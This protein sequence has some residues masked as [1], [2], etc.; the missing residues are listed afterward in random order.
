[1]GHLSAPSS[2]TVKPMKKVMAQIKEVMSNAAQRANH[3]RE[4]LDQIDYNY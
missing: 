4:A 2:R 3:H 1:M